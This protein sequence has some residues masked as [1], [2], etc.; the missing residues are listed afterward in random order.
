MN[1]WVSVDLEG[2]T[3]LVSEREMY[4][5]REDFAIARR[6]MT[7]DANAAIAGA[8]D[9]GARTVVVCDSHGPARTLLVEELDPRATLI[10]GGT[11]PWRMVEGLDRDVDAAFLVGY[12]GRAGVG[13]AV[14]SHT[15]SGDEL[16]DLKIGGA[17]AGEIRL[18]SSVAGHHGVPVVLVTGDDVA[19]AEAEATLPGVR[20]AEVKRAIDRF[21]AEVRHPDVTRPLIREAAARALRE[22]EDW[23]VLEA[24]RPFEIAVV[25]ASPSVAA[26]CALIPG[27]RQVSDREVAYTGETVLDAYRTFVAMSIVAGSVAPHPPYG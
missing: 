15:W 14:L 9:A 7:S 11:K 2:V 27:V 18:V 21:A 4:A 10:R 23:H 13:P 12:H 8:F 19:C 5:D 24:A 22:R 6:L 26:H 16:L 1:V 17:P 25:W 20:T 3:G